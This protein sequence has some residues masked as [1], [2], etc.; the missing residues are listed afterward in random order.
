MVVPFGRIEVLDLAGGTQRTIVKRTNWAGDTVAPAVASDG[1]TIVYTRVNSWLT[2]P[3]FGAALYSVRIDGAH[4]RRITPFKLGGGDHPAF[5]PAGGI[6]FR[7]FEDQETR[8]SDF[9]TVQ[10]NGAALKQLTHFEDGTLVRSGS[11]SPDG[12]WIVHASDGVPGNADLYVMRSNATGNRPLTRTKAW[13]SA[14][15]W[16]PPGI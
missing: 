11:Y 3:Q 13:D 15:D 12:R 10:R 7:S 6:L 8:Q 5:S 1:R 14:S 16:G 4:D 9:W 2:K